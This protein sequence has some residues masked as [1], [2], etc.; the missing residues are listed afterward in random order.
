MRTKSFKEN[1][2]F[3]ALN[4]FPRKKGLNKIIRRLSTIEDL[5]VDFGLQHFKLCLFVNEGG[6]ETNS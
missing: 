1:T 6:E 2:H 5:D 3:G 4:L